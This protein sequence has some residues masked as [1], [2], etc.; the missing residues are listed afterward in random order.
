MYGRLQIHPILHKSGSS[1]TGGNGPMSH[2]I[3]DMQALA[4]NRARA[5]N[6]A[7]PAMFL[8]ERAIAQLKERLE[9]VNRTFTSVAIVTAFPEVWAKCVPGATM[10]PEA[11]LLEFG[12][13]KHDLVIHALSLHW[14]NDPV[15]QMI[16]CRNAL[17]PDGMFLAVLFGGQTLHELRASIA[18]AEVKLHGGLSPRVAPM[19]EL[20]DLGGLLQRAGFA[21][22]VADNDRVTV[23]YKT[24][25]DLMHDL[26]AMGEVNVMRERRRTT[27]TSGFFS[28]ISDVYNSTFMQNI[29]IL[30]ATFDMIYLTGWA[31]D[32]SQ[33]QPLRP[34][35]AVAR[36]ADA[37]GVEEFGEP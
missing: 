8:H 1:T 16:Q 28:E 37:L 36:L 9:E 31:P 23:T 18:E 27:L 17:Q 5:R 14:A 29:N 35:S 20:R 19:A 21:L 24:V 22:P 11:E 6:S 7:A 12:A 25:L 26:R 32:P 34:G 3:F 15:G 33:Q 2:E 10:I 4:R 13:E 30:P